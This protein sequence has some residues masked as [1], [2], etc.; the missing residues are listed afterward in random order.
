MSLLAV[1]PVD[2]R[3]LGKTTDLRSYFSEM[4]LI[5]YRLK[6]EVK[7]FIA[8]CELPLPQLKDIS[9]K[10]LQALHSIVNEFSEKAFFIASV[11][12]FIFPLYFPIN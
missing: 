9:T 5:K 2:G 3:Y 7:Y 12:Y 6:T 10:N 8:L 1:S 4:A 11:I